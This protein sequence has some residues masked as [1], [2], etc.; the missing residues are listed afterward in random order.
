MSDQAFVKAF[1][2]RRPVSDRPGRLGESDLGGRDPDS[3]MTSEIQTPSETRVP[4]PGQLRDSSRAHD[5][6]GAGGLHL[7]QSVASTARVWVD[8]PAEQ[9]SRAD[10]AESGIPSPHLEALAG[11]QTQSA[12]RYNSDV[13]LK[14]GQVEIQPLHPTSKQQDA[15]SASGTDD[16][17]QHIHN[18]YASTFTDAASFVNDEVSNVAPEDVLRAMRQAESRNLAPSFKLQ[19]ELPTSNESPIGSEKLPEQQSGP[20]TH[21]RALELNEGVSELIIENPFAAAA[22]GPAETLPNPTDFDGGSV[23][24]AHAV[25]AE[26]FQADTVDEFVSASDPVEVGQDN[27]Q[28]GLKPFQAVWEV[29]VLD[30]P[31]MVADLFFEGRLFQQIAERMSDAIESGL[32]SVIVTS[33]KAGE[34]RS[35]VAVGLAMA[36]AAAGKRVALVDANVEQPNLADELRLELQ[37]GWVDTIRAG[38]PI[39]EVAVH[40]VEDGVTLIPLMPPKGKNA[41]TGH[42]VVQLV[43]L[44]KEKFELIILDGPTSQSSQIQ[45]CASAVDS[46]IIVRDMTRTDTLAINEFSYRLRESGVQGVGVVENFS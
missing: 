45:Q 12:E 33:T 11:E 46:A 18:A 44:L 15:S 35:S 31:T 4:E 17:V 22:K 2:R 27:P 41:A 29:D 43:E 42:E 30:V 14:D 9:V 21:A 38:L 34:G 6:D 8:H 7:D 28:A 23:S 10:Y 5:G 16:P 1:S 20:V 19:Y 26:A 3:Q 36:A 37:Y 13:Y 32:N 39:R 40:A 24:A 25:Q